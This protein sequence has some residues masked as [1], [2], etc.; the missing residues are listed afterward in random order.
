MYDAYA[1]ILFLNMN[2]GMV[3]TII[4]SLYVVVVGH[5]SRVRKEE[6]HH[7]FGVAIDR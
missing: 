7:E 2:R 5:S 6:F 4:V 1:A 3:Q